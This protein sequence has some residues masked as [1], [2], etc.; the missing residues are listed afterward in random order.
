MTP[1]SLPHDCG[2]LAQARRQQRRGVSRNF[3]GL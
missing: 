3:P 1:N 2:G